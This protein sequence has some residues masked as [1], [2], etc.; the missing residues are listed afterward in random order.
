MVEN[1]K[2][3]RDTTRETEVEQSTRE[4]MNTFDSGL[5]Y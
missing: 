3:N 4:A 2:S 1:E 5:D